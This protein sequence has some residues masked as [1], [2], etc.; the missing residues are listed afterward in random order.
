LRQR[1]GKNTVADYRQALAHN[2]ALRRRRRR[3]PR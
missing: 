3:R 2:A 1:L